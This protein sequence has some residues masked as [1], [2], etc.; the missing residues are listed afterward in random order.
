MGAALVRRVGKNV[1]LPKGMGKYKYL[2][3]IRS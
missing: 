3:I 2:V 1:N